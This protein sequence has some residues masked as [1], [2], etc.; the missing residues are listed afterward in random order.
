MISYKTYGLTEEQL[1]LDEQS[2]DLMVAGMH[3]AMAFHYE[4]AQQHYLNVIERSPNHPAGYFGLAFI[5][6]NK[7]LENSM[8]E[9]A[10]ESFN[11]YVQMAISKG[12]QLLDNPDQSLGALFFYALSLGLDCRTKL[13]NKRLIEAISQGNRVMQLLDDIIEEEPDFVDA[14]VM[15]AI[16][17]YFV[18]IVPINWKGVLETLNITGNRILGLSLLNK[19]ALEGLFLKEAISFLTL[20]IQTFYEKNYYGARVLSDK[21]LENF[22][23]NLYLYHTKT[24]I[25]MYSSEFDAAQENLNLYIDKVNQADDWHH[26]CWEYK[27]IFMQGR[28][29]FAQRSYENGIPFFYK[30]IQMRRE[31]IYEDYYV[32]YSLLRLGMIYDIIGNRDRAVE[33]YQIS[34]QTQASTKV[35]TLSKMF[36]ESP[37]F[38]GDTRVLL[39]SEVNIP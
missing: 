22:P 26:Q 35:V 11:T 7:L 10:Q 23:D 2:V 21:L 27:T 17:N 32:A 28:L 19:I 13:I 12:E 33:F 3:E 37:Y 25:L 29:Y 16:Y 8:D 36:L 20:S 4:L 9:Q 24:Y 39:G 6:G 1:G 14:Y 18:G 38:E 34:A 31:Y 15:R 30:V 5:E